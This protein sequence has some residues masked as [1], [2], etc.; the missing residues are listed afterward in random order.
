MEECERIRKSSSEFASPLVFIWKKSTD[1]HLCTDF[2]R[3]NAQTIKDT[4]PLP[5]QAD[6]LV[7]LGGNAYFSTMDLTSGY[8]NVEI[9]E[10]DWKFT[11]FT[12]PFSLYDYNRL[13]QGLCN[14]PATFMWMMLNIFRDQNFLSLLCYLH[15]V[16][17]FAPSEELGLQWLEMVFSRLKQHNLNPLGPVALLAGPDR[18]FA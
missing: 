8:Y 14:S 7:A 9:H 3:L 10:E 15:D 12:S 2:R 1:L 13:P 11:T 5:H 4:H 18:N 17:V 16:L 6:A